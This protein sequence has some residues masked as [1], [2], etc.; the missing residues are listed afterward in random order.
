MAGREAVTL[1]RLTIVDVAIMGSPVVIVPL[2]LL[3][4]IATVWAT[5]R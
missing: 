4:V 5:S 3:F 1:G 2:L